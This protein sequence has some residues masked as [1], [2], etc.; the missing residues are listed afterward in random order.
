MQLDASQ[1]RPLIASNDQL[2]R[3]SI[4]QIINTDIAERP[5]LV[6]NG[7][8]YGTRMRRVLFDSV[9]SMIAVA[10]YE[11]PRALSVWEPRIIVG[12]VDATEQY[13]ADGAAG[14]I[15]V[16]HFRYRSTNRPDNFVAPFNL[17]SP[18]T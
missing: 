8:P 11:I 14:I 12:K 5:W 13:L 1:A 7:V 18:S 3:M 10:Q 16:I 15:A 4:D 2:V 17:M 6:L 9:A